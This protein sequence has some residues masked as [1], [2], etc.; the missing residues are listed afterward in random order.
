MDSG[1]PRIPPRTTQ[2]DEPRRARVIPL[3]ARRPAADKAADD[4]GD[5]P[6]TLLHEVTA[7]KYSGDAAGAR[8][9]ASAFHQLLAPIAGGTAYSLLCG[10]DGRPY[11]ALALG[12]VSFAFAAL[13]VGRERRWAPLLPFMATA[14]RFAAP[15]LGL[16]FLVCLALLAHMPNSG[17]LQFA[18][19]FAATTLFEAVGSWGLQRYVARERKTRVAVIGSAEGATSLARELSL[20]GA[21]KYVVVG[22]VA[23]VPEGP[24][25]VRDEVPTLGELRNIGSLVPRHKIDLLV[26][27]G[28]VPRLDVFNEIA[29]ACLHLP[30]RLHELSG[31]Y[32]DVFGHVP[33]AEINAS[34]F[35]YIMHPR[36]R[37]SPPA[38]KRALDL[39]IAVVAGIASLP[40][41]M[42]FVLLIRRDGGPVLFKQLR[43]GEGGRPFTVYKLRTMRVGAPRAAQ[44]ASADD[45]RVTSIG[46]FLRRTHLDEMPQLINVLKGEMSVVGPRPEQP[47]FV[48][49]LEAW[50]PYYTRR[51]LVKPGITGWAQVRCG[52]AGS[53][54]GSAWK[55]CHD[56]YYLKHRSMSLDLVI[57]G[58]TIRT[59]VADRQYSVEPKNVSFIL[60][61]DWIQAE[62]PTS[63]ASAVSS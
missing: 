10:P 36:Y 42:L 59:L 24:S 34:W 31:F 48:E 2:A 9:A 38:S 33:V 28:E 35:Q 13:L 29:A 20:S 21:T 12:V 22:R 27:T 60:N 4:R 54:V 37:S 56:L 15:L 40:L 49:R 44:W 23:G 46:R 55:L 41:M 53:D 25:E 47:E 45:P 18:G 11:A 57:L 43:I 39:F 62:P 52:Y 30:V 19:A 26:M 51:H 14:S 50:V 7:T 17:P 63:P 32:E 5:Q 16:V 58:E 1:V 3:L 6:M 61:S 8:A